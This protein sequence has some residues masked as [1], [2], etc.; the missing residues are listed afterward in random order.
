MIVSMTRENDIGMSLVPS[1]YVP[2]P[3]YPME[4]LHWKEPIMLVHIA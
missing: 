4:Q 1:Q 2:F 3:S